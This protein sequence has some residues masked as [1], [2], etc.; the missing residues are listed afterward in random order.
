[1]EIKNNVFVVTGGASGLGGGT[2]RML[3]QAGGKVVIADVQA[4]KGEAMARELGANVRFMKCDVTTEADGQAA[5]RRS[6]RRGRTGW[7]ASSG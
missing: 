6:A 4:D 1:M 3:A 5:R 7:P 2:V